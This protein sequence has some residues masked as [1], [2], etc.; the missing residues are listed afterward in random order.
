[1]KKARSIISL[2]LALL[3]TVSLFGGCEVN[4]SREPAGGDTGGTGTGDKILTLMVESSSPA[5]TVARAT[6][7]EFYELTGYNIVVDS[8]AYSGFYEKLMS[9][10][11]SGNAGHDIAAIDIVWFS[12][13]REGLL[14]LGDAV[15]DDIDDAV[16]TLVDGLTYD[17]ELYGLPLWTN[18]EVLF[19]RKDLFE[20][21]NSKTDF[22]TRYGY[23]LA[24]PV[25]WQ[26]YKDISEFFTRDQMY[27]STLV[28][29]AG[30]SVVCRLLDFALQAGATGAIFDPDGNLN[31]TTQPYIDGMNFM[32][33]LYNSGVVPPEALA[34][35]LSEAGQF[36]QDGSSALNI[37]WAHGY[38]TYVED[39]GVEKVGV[40]PMISGSAGIASLPG[41]WY[42]AILRNSPNTEIAKEYLQFIWDRNEEYMNAG[43]R[44][45]ARKSIMEKYYGKEGYEVVKVVMDTLDSPQSMNRPSHE[46]WSQIADIIAQHI[47]SCFLGQVDAAAALQAAQNEI[48]ALI[49]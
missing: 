37:G 29:K 28:A 34:M 9:E 8:V 17:G 48:E 5:E 49:A 26:Q 21:E 7:D 39:L 33:D 30:E 1:M 47:Q 11:R 10:M 31:I 43:L 25:D 13:M 3:F 27:G 22:K 15:P 23:D 16:G 35:E 42:N 40:A 2:V 4:D 12:G 46:K 41:P 36:F 18:C 14:P 38:R 20:E 6:A 24:P 45:C 19:Y 32:L 44:L